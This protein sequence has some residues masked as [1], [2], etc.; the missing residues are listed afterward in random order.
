[1][2]SQVIGLPEIAGYVRN[3]KEMEELTSVP[4]G[5]PWDRTKLLGCHATTE[6]TSRSQEHEFMLALKRYSFAG[7]GKRQGKCVRVCWDENRCVRGRGQV[8][9][10]QACG[11]R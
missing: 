6:L 1:V 3:R 9:K 10:L 8:S 7:L 4:I 5:P 2:A 11:G